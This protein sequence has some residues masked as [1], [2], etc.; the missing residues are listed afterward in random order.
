MSDTS[1]SL[2]LHKKKKI[3]NKLDS[4]ESVAKKIVKAK[5]NSFEE[6]NKSKIEKSN[7]ENNN[8]LNKRNTI[9]NRKRANGQSADQV[10]KAKNRKLS[11]T[12]ASTLMSRLEEFSNVWNDCPDVNNYTYMNHLPEN[13]ETKRFTQVNNDRNNSNSSKHVQDY[14]QSNV[15][16]AETITDVYNLSKITSKTNSKTKHICTSSTE[17][18]GEDNKSSVNEKTSSE[19]AD[20]KR[21]K[22][23]LEHRQSHIDQ[24]KLIKQALSALVR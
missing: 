23:V 15:K 24:Q 9:T 19:V 10:K 17:I 18:K 2:K 14:F 20:L 4:A 16:K 12:N 8:V 6:V 13:N 1:D 5:L 7:E 22:A 21:K 11:E 3:L